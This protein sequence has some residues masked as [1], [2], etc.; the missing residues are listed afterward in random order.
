M[1]RRNELCTRPMV[2]SA[3][4]SDAPNIFLLIQSL[5][6]DGTLLFRPL[7]EIKDHISSF[8]ISETPQGEFL[9]CASSY[10][11]GAHLSEVRSIATLPHARGIGAGGLLLHRIL[12]DLKASGTP[13]ACLFTRIPSFFARYGFHTV[14]IASMKDKVAK[15]CLRCS[16]RS[17]CDEIAMVLGEMPTYWPLSSGH[18]LVQIGHG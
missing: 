3:I 14:P 1:H 2:R 16:R 4:L 17:K 15:D 9:G 8:V 5:A 12:E 10:R 13:C 7:Q 18:S 6:G 11:Y